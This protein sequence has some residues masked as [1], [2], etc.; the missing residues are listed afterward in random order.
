MFPVSIPAPA[1]DDGRPRRR[2]ERA[3]LAIL[4]AANELLH[5]NGLDQ[6]SIEG[7][8]ARAGVGKQTIYRW[9][10]NRAALAADAL[11]DRDDLVPTSPNDTGDAIADLRDWAGDLAVAMGSPRGASTM[12]MLT[13][14][15][16]GNEEISRRLHDKFS[17]PLQEQAMAR[18]ASAPD[19]TATYE[20]RRATVDAII[21]LILFRVLAHQEVGRSHTADLVRALTVGLRVDSTPPAEASATAAAIAELLDLDSWEIATADES[22][23]TMAGPGGRTT[24]MHDVVVRAYR[25]A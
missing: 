25:R 7:V 24:T 5:E 21:G 17:G 4:R 9:W 11:L 2:S 22:T 14:A 12:R 10:P 3:R 19:L 15:A 13:A 20:E 16:T 23:R 6:F 8:A 1:A 18:L